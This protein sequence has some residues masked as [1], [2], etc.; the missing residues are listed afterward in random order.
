MTASGLAPTTRTFHPT[1]YRYAVLIDR[2]KHLVTLAQQMEA[3][4]LSALEKR[5][6]EA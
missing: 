1:P 5:D 3:A 6:N 2:A 4:Y